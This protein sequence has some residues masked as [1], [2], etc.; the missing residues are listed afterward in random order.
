MNGTNTC[1]QNNQQHF[2]FCFFF[3]KKLNSNRKNQG[4]NCCMSLYSLSKNRNNLLYVQN[5]HFFFFLYI[6]LLCI[7]L[8]NASLKY[9]P[10]E[11]LVLVQTK[12]VI[13]YELQWL[14]IVKYVHIHLLPEKKKYKNK[15]FLKKKQT[16]IKHTTTT[17]EL[18]PTHLHCY[19]IW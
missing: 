7:H 8:F 11:L 13:I 6:N 12:L 14:E 5:A 19:W 17:Y 9:N 2:C 16:H 18:W 10:I 15:V 1:C 4:S 3:F